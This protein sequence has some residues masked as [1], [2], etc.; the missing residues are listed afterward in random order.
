MMTLNFQTCLWFVFVCRDSVTSTAHFMMAYVPSET[1]DASMRPADRW[2]YSAIN[3]HWDY[4]N[5]HDFYRGYQ[6]GRSRSLFSRF[7]SVEVKNRLKMTCGSTFSLLIFSCILH[8]QT[9]VSITSWNI[10]I[11]QIIITF[12]RWTHFEPESSFAKFCKICYATNI[13]LISFFFS[14]RYRFSKVRYQ[15]LKLRL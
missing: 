7:H 5:V 4:K 6:L 8:L 12:L 3:L 11:L 14:S 13:Q 1:T 15:K 2:P 9:C 10:Y